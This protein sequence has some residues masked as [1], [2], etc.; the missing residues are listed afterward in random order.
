MCIFF[1]FWKIIYFEIIGYLL[2]VCDYENVEVEG[3]VVIYKLNL[4]RLV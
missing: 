1:C 2:V 3:N 4:L